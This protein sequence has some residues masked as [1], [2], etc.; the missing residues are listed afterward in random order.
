[1]NEFLYFSII[2]ADVTLWHSM[3]RSLANAAVP[4]HCQNLSIIIIYVN[5]QHEHVDYR[6]YYRLLFGIMDFCHNN[7]GK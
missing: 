3:R 1:M 7:N 5:E 2:K 4:V 6:V